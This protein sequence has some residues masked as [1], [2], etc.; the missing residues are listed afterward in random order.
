MS[1][2]VC[3]HS[4]A[5]ALM[6]VEKEF[7]LDEPPWIPSSGTQQMFLSEFYPSLRTDVPHIS[8]IESMAAR[9][10][11]PLN[12]FL[13]SKGYGQISLGPF[14][15]PTSIGV[16]SILD[17]LSRWLEKGEKT[18]IRHKTTKR[19]YPGVNLCTGLRFF[20]V[21]GYPFPIVQIGT[22]NRS[23]SVFMAVSDGPL[24]GFPLIGKVRE[25]KAAMERLY[26]A[27]DRVIF[28]MVSIDQSEDISWIL[29]IQAPHQSGLPLVIAQAVQQNKLKMDEFG[30]RIQSATAME[31]TL[32]GPS[33]PKPLII[34]QPFFFWYERA[35]LNLP[36]F[37][38]YV[39]EQDWKNPGG[40]R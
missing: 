10:P 2:T 30:V 5:S 7:G 1:K 22:Q 37:V 13:R 25:L 11:E 19:E 28:P 23:D 15:N 26:G 31:G 32:R 20:A 4:V 39:T 38:A 34:D 27:Y 35:D 33:I 24:A 40:L 17:I 36:I 6:Q 8:E 16:V 18:T 9:S 21:P 3:L 14:E 29:E 12:Q